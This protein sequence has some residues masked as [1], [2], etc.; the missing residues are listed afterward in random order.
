MATIEERIR[1][2][3]AKLLTRSEAAAAAGIGGTEEEDVLNTPGSELDR[4]YRQGV[5]ETIKETKERL[6]EAASMGNP[7]ATDQLLRM[8]NSLLT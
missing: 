5:A 6:I 7:V 4:A 2:L 3:G 1:E 8:A